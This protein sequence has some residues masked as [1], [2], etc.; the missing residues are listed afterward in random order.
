MSQPKLTIYLDASA[1]KEASCKRKLIYTIF[2]GFTTHT[3]LQ[4]Y[5]AAY[6]SAIHKALEFWY[7]L[8]FEQRNEANELVAIQKA[9]LYYEPY[10]PY[11][12]TKPTEFRTPSHL[13][14]AL[15][16]YFINYQPEFDNWKPIGNLLESKWLFPIFSNDQF[17]IILCGTID[18]F[19]DYLG[20]ECY[21]DH[22]TTGFFGEDF[23]DKYSFDVQMMLYSWYIERMIGRRLPCVINGVFLKSWTKKAKESKPPYFDGVSFQRSQ[24]IKFSDSQMKWFEGWLMDKVELIKTWVNTYIKPTQSE[25]FG[26]AEITSHLANISY[27]NAGKLPCQYFNICKQA[28]EIQD[29]LLSG[30]LKHPYEPLRFSE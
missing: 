20:E 8:P 2:Y 12:S 19:L 5:K 26:P 18:S 13:E 3:K 11:I 15:K 10:G 1:L 17:E 16:Q 24:K 21:G 23:F 6:G 7:G 27:C 30:L 25:S 9:L 14:Q 29:R 22:K 28:P 4:N